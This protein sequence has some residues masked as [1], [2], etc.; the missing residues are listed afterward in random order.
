MEGTALSVLK[1]ND[2][3]GSDG[4]LPSSPD[5]EVSFNNRYAG[6]ERPRGIT[7]VQR[8]QDMGSFGFAQ[9]DMQGAWSITA[10]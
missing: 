8:A 3:R 6:V 10:L 7:G 9:D 5:P 2:F 4:A 1:V